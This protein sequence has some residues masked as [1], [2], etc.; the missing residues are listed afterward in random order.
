MENVM[1]DRNERILVV[2]DQPNM[3]RMIRRMLNQIGF[4]NVDENDGTTVLREI[5]L[6]KYSLMICDWRMEPQSGLELLKLIRA[7]R[8]HEDLPFIMLTAENSLEAVD[9]ARAAGAQDFIAKPVSMQTLSDK[10][11]RLLSPSDKPARLASA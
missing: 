8:D 3:R 10:I 9:Q 5:K 6:Y 11:D 4:R 7:D 2:E 1:V